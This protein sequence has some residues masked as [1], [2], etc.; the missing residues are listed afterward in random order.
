MVLT[1]YYSCYL[2]VGTGGTTG[3]SELEQ[4]WARPIKSKIFY[5]AG[6]LATPDYQELD[7]IFI[8]GGYDEDQDDDIDTVVR[9]LDDKG[10]AHGIP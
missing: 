4:S 3:F 1:F 9:R 2:P 6:S 5:N 8:T 10:R 7:V